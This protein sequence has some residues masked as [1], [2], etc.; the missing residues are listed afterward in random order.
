MTPLSKKIAGLPKKPG[1]YLFK[2]AQGRVIYVGKAKN[3]R[4]RVRNYT[5]PGKDG[6][7]QIS[8]LMAK[9]RDL[10]FIVTATEKEALLLEGSLIKNHR[11]RYNLALRDDKSFVSLRVGT[12]HPSPG[13]SLT[14]RPKKDRAT[15]YGPYD[16]ALAAR[17]ALDLI[18]SHF[19]IRSCSDREFAN[20]VRPC[21]QH[22]IG[23]CSA[24][25]VSLVSPADY[26]R[27]VS[28]VQMFLGG[29]SSELM[30]AI[31]LRMRSASATLDFEEAARWRDVIAMMRGIRQPQQVVKHGGGDCDVIALA[32]LGDEVCV[33]ALEVRRGVLIGKKIH[34]AHGAHG[35]LSKLTEEFLLQHY[36]DRHAIPEKIISS[37]R[38]ES[39]GAL[40]SLLSD[41]AG[42]SIQ[43]V[44]AAQ[45]KK[46]KL[47]L[48]ALANAEEA[49]R[50]RSE[51]PEEME[52]LR[53]IGHFFRVP[54]GINSIECV[55]ISSTGGRDAVGAIVR[56]SAGL[57]D[58]SGYRIY[59]IRTLQIPDAY[60]MIRE[61]L[62]RRFRTPPYPDLLLVDGGKGQLAVA[63]RIL[64]ELDITT[65]VAAIAK[66]DGKKIPDRI[67]IPKRKNPLPFKRGSR[68]LMMLM[69]IRDEVHRF[70]IKAH[71]KRRAKSFLRKKHPPLQKR[72]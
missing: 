71:R 20:R 8:F 61:V 2:D 65:A 45:S 49:L 69:R 34:I 10:D 5:R 6:R 21:L 70:G 14:R 43:I 16:S 25:C 37:H 22:D 18:T 51:R 7:A 57:P 59:H 13:I 9:V 12:D 50:Q 46:Q 36:T 68:A 27:Q 40:A 39:A 31:Q 53:A 58:T 72:V 62:D 64:G 26:A 4:L 3:L 32:T 15:Y 30:R 35:D 24:P 55:D 38:L 47:V 52:A 63:T 44:Q 48:L 23:R 29:Q 41:R 56:F 67:F 28:D 33:L 11:P 54:G 42:R 66:G 17:E 60:G 1:V 19:Q